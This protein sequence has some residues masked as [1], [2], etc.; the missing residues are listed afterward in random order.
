MQRLAWQP[1]KLMGPLFES[2]THTHT[3]CLRQDK[4]TSTRGRGCCCMPCHSLILATQA[5]RQTYLSPLVTHTHKQTQR[6]PSFLQGSESRPWGQSKAKE[7]AM[8]SKQGQRASPGVKKK[9]IAENL[10]LY[11]SQEQVVTAISLLRVR[12]LGAC[13]RVLGYVNLCNWTCLLIFVKV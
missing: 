1:K 6:Y 9:K 12:V 11:V 5:N 13:I 2:H 4:Q 3:S 10:C 8:G 7:Q